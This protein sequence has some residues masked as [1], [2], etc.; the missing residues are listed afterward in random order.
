PH[1]RH[2]PREAAQLQG[3]AQGPP[4]E[5]RGPRRP[6]ARVAPC[7]DTLAALPYGR[8]VVVWG[9]RSETR[10]AAPQGRGS[11]IAARL[12][13]APARRWLQAVLR[14]LHRVS[15]AADEQH[16]ALVVQQDAAREEAR[17][18]D[19]GVEHGLVGVGD[20]RD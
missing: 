20:D 2:G 1:R 6:P 4:Q 12:A 15:H 11:S 8:A 5:A 19:D 14:L 17:G 13:L 9:S 3:G 7:G 16:L 10:R 18:L